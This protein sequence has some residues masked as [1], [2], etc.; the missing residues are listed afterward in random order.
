MMISEAAEKLGTDKEKSLLLQHMVI[1]HHGEPEFGAAVR[2]LFLEAVL[3]SQLDM[4]DANVYEIMDALS[5]TKT[6]EFT[7]RLWALNDRKFYKAND[8]KIKV[9]LF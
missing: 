2:P 9:N 5:S 4:M 1:S 7:N 8:E 3:L 6:G